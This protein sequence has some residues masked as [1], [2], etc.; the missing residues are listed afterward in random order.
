VSDVLTHEQVEDRLRDYLHRLMPKEARSRYFQKRNGPMFF[1]T[2]EPFNLRNPDDIAQGKYESVVY[3]PYGPGSRS[4]KATRWKRD[5]ST[6][7]LHALRK[8][9]KARA[10]RLYRE[11]LEAAA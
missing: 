1:W 9:A 10:L 4:G 11:W 5:E 7:M 8:D 6:A 2:V 3:V